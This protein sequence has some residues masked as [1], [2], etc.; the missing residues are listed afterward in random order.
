METRI[1]SEWK[2]ANEQESYYRKPNQLTPSGNKLGPIDKSNAE[3]GIHSHRNRRN[4][5]VFHR[6]VATYDLCL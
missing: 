6:V 5:S 2:Q 4:S 1:F 3:V